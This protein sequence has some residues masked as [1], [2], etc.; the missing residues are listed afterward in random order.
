M[1]EVKK[2]LDPTHWHRLNGSETLTPVSWKHLQRMDTLPYSVIFCHIVLFSSLG[3]SI[4]IILYCNIAHLCVT[5]AN[6]SVYHLTDDGDKMYDV[7]VATLLCDWTRK[8]SRYLNP[9]YIYY[10]ICTYLV[11]TLLVIYYYSL[12]WITG[13]VQPLDKRAFNQHFTIVPHRC[14]SYNNRRKYNRQHMIKSSNKTSM[15]V[16]H[17][18]SRLTNYDNYIVSLFN[19]VELYILW[20]PSLKPS[21]DYMQLLTLV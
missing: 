7:K 6:C 15:L 21:K 14:K 11:C 4:L 13:A 9:V 2:K 16:L 10:F 20:C 3:S 19:C 8:V 1:S 12:V 17:N 18:L 5:L